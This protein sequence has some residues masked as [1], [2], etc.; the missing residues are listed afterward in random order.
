M[1]TETAI[2]TANCRFISPVRGPRIDQRARLLVGAG[3]P[4]AHE[5]EDPSIRNVQIGQRNIRLGQAD[6]GASLK[7]LE[8]P[9]IKFPRARGVLL[10]QFS[11][12]SDLPRGALLAGRPPR[13][14]SLGNL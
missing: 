3:D 9:V 7:L 5:G 11:E 2:V 12:P 1:A 8:L 14:L 13:E 6:V 10:G 4:A